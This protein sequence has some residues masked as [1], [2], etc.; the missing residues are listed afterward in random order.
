MKTTLKDLLKKIGKNENACFVILDE[1]TDVHNVG[2]IIRSSV[3]TG[4]DAIIMAKHNQ[5]PI[6]ETVVRTSA[7]TAGMIPVIETN[8]ND[9]IRT[10]KEHKFW[11][12]GLF[13]NGGST[14]WNSDLTGRVAI[15]VGSEGEGIHDSTK[16]LCDFS[17]SIPM[18]KRVESLNASVSAAVALYE[19][20]RQI[21][22]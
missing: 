1:L 11:V 3:A 2:A 14:L 15:V 18:D 10:L 4:A 5:A 19:R 9:A 13:M 8:V 12:H 21:S 17:L 6:N 20:L 7:G 16:K 22:K